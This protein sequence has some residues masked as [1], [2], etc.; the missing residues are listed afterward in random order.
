MDQILRASNDPG[1]KDLL[2]PY[3]ADRQ[4]T[5]ALK[6]YRMDSLHRAPLRKLAGYVN[7]VYPFDEFPVRKWSR[8][9]DKLVEHLPPRPIMAPTPGQHSQDGPRAHIQNLCP[10]QGHTDRC[11][12]RRSYRHTTTRA[13]QN[14]GSGMA[15]KGKRKRHLTSFLCLVGF[16]GVI[17]HFPWVWY[18][19][20]KHCVCV[21]GG[22]RGRRGCFFLF[23]GWC[24]LGWGLRWCFIVCFCFLCLVCWSGMSFRDFTHVVVVLSGCMSMPNVS[25]LVWR[26]VGPILLF[27]WPSS[28]IMALSQATIRWFH[29]R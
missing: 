3:E 28:V 4:V 22:P 17:S 26:S 11:R 21:F 5:T 25:I 7:G 13:G 2:L 8:E 14:Y 24:L 12:T 29:V 9:Q 1:V 6:T 20:C 19:D 15:M 23:R 18:L 10:N 16:L 27:V